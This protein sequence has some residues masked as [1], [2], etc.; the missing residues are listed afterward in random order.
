MPV[1]TFT[2]LTDPLATDGFT[3]PSG[4]N[5]SGNIVGFYP[6]PSTISINGF[7]YSGG[8]Y[9]T[10]ADPLATIGTQA[11]GINNA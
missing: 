9:T 7:L 11:L 2:T 8:T 10:I 6:A 3:L 5:A 4:I 1:Y